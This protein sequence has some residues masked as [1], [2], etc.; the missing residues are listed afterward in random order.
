MNRTKYKPFREENRRLVSL[1]FCLLK[2]SRVDLC[3][4]RCALPSF[5]SFI[6][7][8]PYRRSLDRSNKMRSLDVNLLKHAITKFPQGKH[9][10]YY[11]NRN[12][13]LHELIHLQTHLQNSPTVEQRTKRDMASPSAAIEKRLLGVSFVVNLC[14]VGAK[15]GVFLS[16]RSFSVLVSLLD[17]AIDIVSSAIL[18]VTARAI[19]RSTSACAYRFPIGTA[20]LEP[21]GTLVFSIVMAVAMVVAAAE[22]FAALFAGLL[23][24]LSLIRHGPDL[25]AAAIGILSA[26]VLAKAVLY[27]VSNKQAEHAS[28]L[29]KAC[30]EDHRNDTVS[31]L[32]SLSG[33]TLAA[34]FSSV[35]WWLDPVCAIV[36]A[37]AISIL[38]T[39]A[40]RHQVTML[41]GGAASPAM[42]RKLTFMSFQHDP[43]IAKVDTVRAYYGGSKLFV[44]IHI[45]MD[46]VTPLWLAHDVGES[47]EQD[48][49]AYF[50]QDVERAFVHV[51]YETTHRPSSEHLGPW[52]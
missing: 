3:V 27:G 40:S 33:G 22:S 4:S 41:T 11:E 23:D 20:R 17:S 32:L 13:H 28:D 52:V 42:L 18:W 36:L 15:L 7:F 12:A 9:Q 44:E 21:V 51:D 35:L 19:A 29:L 45:V 39:R 34:E 30:T 24:S 6:H 1:F 46:P 10:K 25:G 43:R 48:V 14:L 31:N 26:T 16:S 38:W 2:Q 49:E 47:L 50:F 8:K 37:T 5:S